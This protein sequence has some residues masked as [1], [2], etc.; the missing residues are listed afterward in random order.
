MKTQI[1]KELPDTPLGGD[2]RFL[3]P[4]RNEWRTKRVESTIINAPA[5]FYPDAN[6]PTEVV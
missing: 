3:K 2:N 6:H 4:L 1:L 5:I